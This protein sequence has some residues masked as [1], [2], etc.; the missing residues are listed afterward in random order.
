MST[1]K[2][3]S[4]EQ[5]E[6]IQSELNDKYGVEDEDW[7]GGPVK[8]KGVEKFYA[9]K[10]PSAEVWLNFKTSRDD[11]AIKASYNKKPTTSLSNII[12]NLVSNCVIDDVEGCASYL[13]F[14]EDIKL[15]PA[16]VEV[17]ADLVQSLHMS[18]LDG[19]K[20]NQ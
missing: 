5:K 17:L 4:E 10:P 14:K 13:E 6:K 1:N 20:K 7:A 15:K 3:L 11:F 19:L 12:T 9:V 16:L 8:I 2:L 18:G